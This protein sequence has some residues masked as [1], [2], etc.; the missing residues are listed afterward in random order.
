MAATAPGL[1]GP[2]RG[3]ACSSP[4]IP[5]PLF[6]APRRL[7]RF[8]GLGA[9]LTPSSHSSR[10]RPHSDWA[11]GYCY[12]PRFVTDALPSPS[13]IA[14]PSEPCEPARKG[15]LPSLRALAIG[16]QAIGAFCFP[17]RR[18][19]VS[20]P[21]DGEGP[22]AGARAAGD[23]D[24]SLPPLVPDRPPPGFGRSRVLPLDRAA[25]AGRPARQTVRVRAEVRNEA[26]GAGP[27][28]GWEARRRSGRGLL[29]GTGRSDYVR[30]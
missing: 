3:A 8:D 6:R 10:L 12:G 26:I 5:A 19:T 7:R 14:A 25:A 24:A 4:P 28:G 23:N 16:F 9:L 18:G 21:L 11:G 27:L 2:R 20:R 30:P 13:V 17:G 22:L 1:R 29:G 15:A